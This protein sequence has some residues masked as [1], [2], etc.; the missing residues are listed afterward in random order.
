M[1]DKGKVFKIRLGCLAISFVAVRFAVRAARESFIWTSIA[2]A[3]GRTT[4]VA[5]WLEA[6]KK[7][8][9]FLHGLESIKMSKRK[10][11]SKGIV[12]TCGETV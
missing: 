11:K 9:A 3:G 5:N 6:R 4:V 8:N 10:D 1:G 12:C 7:L 2:D